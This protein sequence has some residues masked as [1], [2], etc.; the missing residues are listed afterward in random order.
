MGAP[1]YH[2]QR[3][4]LSNDLGG[5][6]PGAEQFLEQNRSCWSHALLLP[7]RRTTQRTFNNRSD[8]V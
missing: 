2:G 3:S 5:Y 8:E 1:P 4:L 6:C 7:P